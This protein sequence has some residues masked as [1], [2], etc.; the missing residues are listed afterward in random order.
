MHTLIAAPR[1]RVFD[2]VADL[3]GRPAYTDHYLDDYRLARA[4]PWGEGAAAR[5]RVRAP[6]AKAYGGLEIKEVDRPRRIVEELHLGRRDRNRFVAVYEFSSEPGGM[7]GVELTTFGEPA[8]RLDALRQLGAAGWTRR[9]TKMALERLRMIFE[10]PPDAPL[11]RATVAGYE[12]AT[13]P[14]FG[15]H[16]GMDPGRAL[17]AARARP[18]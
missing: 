10:E 2:F 15:A 18:E 14:R 4:N 13:S 12:P 7:T 16:A 8:T 17:P 3:A 9:Q 1:E 6:L 11:K 5:F